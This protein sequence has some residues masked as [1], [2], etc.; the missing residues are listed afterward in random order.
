MTAAPLCT[1]GIPQKPTITGYKS[2]LREEEKVV[3][4]CQSS[5]SKP[6]ARLTWRKGEKELPG[7][8]LCPGW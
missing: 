3:L 2:S 4:S 5:G 1:A 7:E 6:A 8:S